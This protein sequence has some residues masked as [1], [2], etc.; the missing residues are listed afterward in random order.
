MLKSWMALP[1]RF[2]RT[3]RRRVESPMRTGE[4]SVSTKND[5]ANP[6]IKKNVNMCYE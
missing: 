6:V 5:R 2:V 1:I 4:T 3:C